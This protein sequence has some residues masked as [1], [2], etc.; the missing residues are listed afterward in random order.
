MIEKGI[1]V[2]G[3]TTI[4]EIVKKDDTI[5]HKLGGVTAYAGITYSRHGIRTHVVTNIAAKDS[6]ILKNFYKENIEVHCGATEFTTHFVNRINEDARN[7]TMPVIAKS[8]GYDQI[9]EVLDL[10]DC[11]H[12]GPLHPMDIEIDALA[13]LINSKI[14]IFLDAQG[15]L[16]LI[17]DEI[18]YPGVMGYLTDAL[19][20]SQIVKT[21]ELELEIICRNYAMNLNELMDKF[22]IEE[23]VVSCGKRGGFVKTIRG[24][25]FDYK[26]APIRKYDD[27]TGAGDVFFAAYNVGRFIKKKDVFDASSYAAR[28]AARQVEGEY[29][30]QVQLGLQHL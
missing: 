27:S 20:V 15:Y 9:N 13:S 22:K 10:V 6:H 19:I 1:A 7:Q 24:D 21:D 3:S 29:I 30:R 11:I 17:K 12:L 5:Y 2:I 25:E 26:S 16:R 28:L 8:I 14:P 23:F 18:V 4:D